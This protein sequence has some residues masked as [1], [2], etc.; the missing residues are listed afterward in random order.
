MPGRFFLITGWLFPLVLVLLFIVK[1]RYYNPDFFVPP[2]S[3]IS[4]LPFP[5]TVGDWVLEGGESRP[6]DSM[7]EVINGKADYY[8]QY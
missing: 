3:A 4:A 8:L 7:F 2:V 1:G 5:A 6:G